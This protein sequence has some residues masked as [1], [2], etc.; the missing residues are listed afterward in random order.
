MAASPPTCAD[1]SASFHLLDVGLSMPLEPFLRAK[2]EGLAARG[3][4]V[5]VSASSFDRAGPG[6]LRGIEVVPVPRWEESPARMMVGMLLGS[7]RV[8]VRR[9]SAL[10]ATIRAARHPIRRAQRRRLRGFVAR[11]RSFLPLALMDPDV[12]HVEWNTAAIHYLPMAD[13]WSCPTVVSCRGSDVNMRPHQPN[14]EEYVRCLRMSFD[15]A[16]AIHCVSDAVAARA[17]EL[18]MDPSRAWLVRPAVDPALFHARPATRL[19]AGLF[20][21]PRPLRVVTLGEFRWLKAHEH[22]VRTIA[23]LSRRGVPVSLEVIGGDPGEEVGEDSDRGRIEHA[24][25]HYG[26]DNVVQICE[27]PSPEAVCE[28]LQMADVL[29]H[30]SLTEGLPNVVLEAM[31]CG[32]PVVVG[33][34]DGVGEAVRDG[35]DGFVVPLRG[36]VEAADALQRLYEDEALRRRMGRSG[37]ERIVS[38]FSLQQQLDELLI[39]YQ[40]VRTGGTRSMRPPTVARA[41]RLR[42]LSVGPLS[43]TQGFED[44]MQAVSILLE[45]GIDCRQRIFGEGPHLRALWFTRAQ[46]GLERH[47]E[48]RLG[49]ELSHLSGQALLDPPGRARELLGCTQ[50]RRQLEWADVLLD[51]SLRD[52]PRA[53]L[54]AA[55]EAGVRAIS[56]AGDPSALADALLALVRASDRPA[57]SVLAG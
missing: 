6:S 29:L 11:L 42:L 30:S 9:P 3:V 8:G 36:V 12:V 34:F 5:T 43:W 18:G 48:L 37:R 56:V 24:I 10:L 50:W 35:S 27:A 21:V 33:A 45:R 32:L 17:A 44:A 14:G 28:R 57:V 49:E 39:M 54:T 23:L 19:R 52:P 55:R 15:R 13:V 46:L 31:S 53:A 25:A 40:T 16:T 1:R 26:L 51:A 2:L 47:V 7:L 38:Q 41:R 20:A 22:S 4:R